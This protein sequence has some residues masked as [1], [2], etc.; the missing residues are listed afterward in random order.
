MKSKSW[1]LSNLVVRTLLL[2]CLA[3]WVVWRG[4]TDEPYMTVRPKDLY[5]QVGLGTALICLWL[6]LAAI[7]SFAVFVRKWARAWLVIVLWAFIVLSYLWQSPFGYVHDIMETQKV[8][9]H[10]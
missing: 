10:S 8:G 7:V 1:I 2:T 9:E 6:Q 5:V 4:A 3:A